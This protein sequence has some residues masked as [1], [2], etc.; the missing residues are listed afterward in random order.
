LARRKWEKLKIILE[1]KTAF[2]IEQV[3]FDKFRINT[4]RLEL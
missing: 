1:D 3:I 4:L 2:M